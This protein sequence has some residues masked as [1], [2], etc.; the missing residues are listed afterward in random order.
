MAAVP[1]VSTNLMRDGIRRKNV[2]L[3]TRRCWTSGRHPFTIDIQKVQIKA[4]VHRW[5]AEMKVGVPAK[6][7]MATAPR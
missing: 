4:R 2:E 6:L 1:R 5:R 7:G 3:W